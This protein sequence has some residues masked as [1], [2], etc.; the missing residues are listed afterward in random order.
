MIGDGQASSNQKVD[1]GAGLPYGRPGG[2]C[3]G[4]RDMRRKAS[5]SSTASLNGPR[6]CAA[7]RAGMTG[8]RH[9]LAVVPRLRR[10]ESAFIASLAEIVCGAGLFQ[11]DGITLARARSMWLDGFRTVAQAHE[12]YSSSA[13]KMSRWRGSS[14]RTAPWCSPGA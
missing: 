11:A 9:D 10:R 12:G 8:E 2:S 13:T 5:G 1:K 3:T 14:I 7:M 4:A 6:A